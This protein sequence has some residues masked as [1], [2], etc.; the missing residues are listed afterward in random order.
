MLEAVRRF[1]EA[2]RETLTPEKAESLARALIREGQARRD[3]A[4]RLARELTTWS[5]RN[6]ERLMSSIR[7]EV[8]AQISKA[9][10]ATKDEVEALKRR[11]R[12]LESASRPAAKRT[13]RRKASSAKA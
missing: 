8:K 12:K 4:A 10:L 3:Q 1:V 9:G 2:G 11:I 7:S 13:T 5:R 6:S